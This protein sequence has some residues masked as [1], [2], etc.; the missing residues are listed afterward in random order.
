[1]IK[2]RI[3]Y[4]VLLLGLFIFYIYCNSYISLFVIYM[5]LSL[6]VLSG[7]F[8]FISAKGVSAAVSRTA[9][10]ANV[11]SRVVEF[12]T[13]I[14]NK[15]FLPAP[16]IIFEIA[17]KD[18]SEQGGISRSV[19]TSL[20][21]FD[22]RNIY[23]SMNAPFAALIEASVTKLRVCDCFGIFS[24][25]VKQKD[26]GVSVLITP[27][28]QTVKRTY[29]RN[30]RS[31]TDSDV[32]SDTKK[33]DDRSQV[34]ELREYREGDDLRNVHWGLSSKHDM[35]IVKEF[36]LPIEESCT[37]LIESSLGSKD[38]KETKRR[39]DR[40]LAEFTALSAELISNGQFFNACFYSASGKR[41]SVYEVKKL[42]DIAV[43][44]KT[45]LSEKLAGEPSL[46]YKTFKAS[47]SASG[48]YY[49]YD[50]SV[51]GAVRELDENMTA[52]DVNGSTGEGSCLT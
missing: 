51:S 39:A 21:S 29:K 28:S 24:F 1:M 2:H 17:F 15:G 14:K 6:T 37:V 4:A 48:V 18:A 52:V 9:S 45:F 20:G 32:Y 34:F 16:I 25:P 30:V 11:S 44:L 40:V 13:E 50:S 33:G 49:I 7:V 8:A 31:V 43:V 22:S 10:E 41:L 36:S 5:V 26:S 46:S 42:E 12:C 38:G 27:S 3:T 19:R 47:Q 23:I 35:L